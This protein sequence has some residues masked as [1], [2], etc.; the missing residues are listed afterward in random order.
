M[1][2]ENNW[3]YSNLK[4]R[5][6]DKSVDFKLLFNPRPFNYMDFHDAAD[7]AA[8]K[9]ANK[10]DKIF[11]ALSGGIDSEYVLMCLYRCNIPVIP[12]IVNATGHSLEIEYALHMCRQLDITPII[13]ECS[14]DLYLSVYKNM[15]VDTINGASVWFTPAI[16]ASKY[17]AD[18]G[19]VLITGEHLIDDEQKI[20]KASAGDCGFY[21]DT[22]FPERPSYDLLNYTPKIVYA[23]ISAFDGSDLADFKSNLYSLDWRPKIKPVFDSAFI[24]ALQKIRSTRQFAPKYIDVLGTREKFLNYMRT[25]N[26]ESDNHD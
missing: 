14:D 25:W 3:M 22:L 7:E 4:E 2:T 26:K 20:T 8:V 17:A 24:D 15:I 19:G 6:L 13:L 23:I 5:F 9:I 11:V 16:I 21:L 1:P 18:H 10:H 12:I